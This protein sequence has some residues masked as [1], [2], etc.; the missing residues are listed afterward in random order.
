MKLSEVSAWLAS[1]R[2]FAAGAAIYAAVGRS[3][4][5][6]RLFALGETPYS[7]QVLE[8]ELVALV[9]EVK[10]EIDALS[11]PLPPAAPETLAPAPEPVVPTGGPAS[12]ALAGLRDQL[13]AVR[14]ERSHL[15]P[16]LTAKNLGK[17]ARYAVGAR[18]L[19]LTD[20]E[21]RLKALEAHVLEHGRLPGPVPTADITDTGVLRQRL[22]NLVSLRTKLRKKPARAADLAAAEE[23]IILI[24]SKLNP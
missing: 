12:P 14:D 9:R 17:T 4:T 5:Y 21:I 23:E 22:G 24:R 20:E 8:R 18:I 1:D 10:T 7:R 3:K 15:H 6:Q 13:K 19:D 16:Q 11:P 2:S